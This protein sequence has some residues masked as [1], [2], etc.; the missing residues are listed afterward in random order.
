ME[1]DSRG[2]HTDAAAFE[3]DRIRDAK[4][5]RAGQ[6]VLRITYRRLSDHPADV[7]DDIRA[8]AADAEAAGHTDVR[9]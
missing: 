2:Y 1:L 5:M 8:L 7:L 9:V 6:R 4:L 3:T